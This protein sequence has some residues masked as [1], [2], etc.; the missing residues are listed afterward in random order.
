MIPL[1]NTNLKFL[2]HFKSFEGHVCHANKRKSRGRVIDEKLFW[3]KNSKDSINPGPRKGL[4]VEGAVT[5]KF[6]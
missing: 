6:S 3:G 1:A 5:G 2:E 4:R